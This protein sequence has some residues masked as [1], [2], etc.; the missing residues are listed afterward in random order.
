MC[1]RVRVCVAAP[2]GGEICSAGAPI[3]L[4][5]F[6]LGELTGG[7]ALPC[8]VSWLGTMVGSGWPWPVGYLVQSAHCTVGPRGLQMGSG[9]P[10]V[11]RG[12]RVNGRGSFLHTSES[13][14]LIFLL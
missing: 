7:P 11:T 9:L 13:S 5:A 3:Q 2:H 1:V 14:R 10:K 12:G 6:C 4:K 8:F